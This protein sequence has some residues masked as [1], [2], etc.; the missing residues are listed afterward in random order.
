MF[1]FRA[2]F[3]L[4]T[5]F[6]AFVTQVSAVPP[7]TRFMLDALPDMS[8]TG[9]DPSAAVSGVDAS[10]SVS[11]D[12]DVPVAAES[13]PVQENAAVESSSSSSSANSLVAQTNAAGHI[14]V[15]GSTT[16][17]VGSVVVGIAFAI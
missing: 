15:L 13:S 1:V 7:L 14:G 8:E 16:V 11:T 12:S 3:I 17:L 5:P 9:A 6:V 2:V 10:T 4:A